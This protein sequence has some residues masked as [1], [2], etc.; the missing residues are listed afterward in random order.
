M[1]ALSQIGAVQSRE[2]RTETAQ[3][4][5][6]KTHLDHWAS[7]LKKRTFLQRDGTRV[8]VPDYQVRIQHLGRAAYFNLKTA[9]AAEAAPKAREIYVFLIANGWEA[10]LAK[11]KPQP[12]QNSE[13]LT[14]DEFAD[15][16]RGA[17]KEVEYPPL[18]RTAERYIKSLSL[19]CR[20]VAVN[21]ILQLTPPKIKEFKRNYMKTARGKGRDEN[22]IKI[23]CNAHLRSAAAIFSKQMIEA[24]SPGGLSI[25]NPF[26]RIAIRRVEIKPY[27][28]MNRDLLD[29]IWEDS[30]KLRDGDPNFQIGK[31]SPQSEPM[32]GPVEKKKRNRW[33]SPDWTQPHPESFMVL[34]L[35]LGVGL[36]RDEADWAQWD[37]F[38]TDAKGRRYIEVKKTQ[39]FTPKGKRRRVI[40]IEP[41]LWNAIQE[42]YQEGDVFI[43]PGNPPIIYTPETEPNNI[44]YR[45]ERHHR[46]LVAWL[47]MKGIN[48]DKP[49]HL[50]RKEFGSY[51]ATSF[52]LFAAQR[53]LGHSSAAVTEGFYA[54][55][56]NLPE[57]NHVKVPIQK[58]A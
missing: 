20:T 32:S 17:L 45:C 14:I 34:V 51:V 54:G 33:K 28:P 53:L 43:I 12:T 49:C 27:T 7:R 4:K 21:R 37:W 31:Q 9:N 22:S 24:Y 8:E 56:T 25:E 19:I 30:V 44:H 2:N 58:T 5:P 16:Y 48:D 39:H 36:R 35:E 6:G 11:Y 29:L 1:N 47:R 41:A 42:W 38:F 3:T 10:T 40:P 26:T 50:L 57:L 13:D 23:S 55:L 46:I 52:G 18:K 15:R